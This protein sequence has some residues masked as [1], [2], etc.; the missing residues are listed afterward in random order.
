[1]AYR[2]TL[3]GSTDSVKHATPKALIILGTVA[4]TVAIHY[5]LILEPIFGHSGWVHAIHGRFCYI[6]IVIA[7]SWFGIRGGLITASVVS[8]S[9]LPYIF[10]GLGHV[11]NR[12][13][14]L[15][16]LVFYFAIAVLT[17]ALIDR[18]WTIRKKQEQTQLQLER[19]HKLSIIGQMAAS[20]AHE[21]KNPLAS[22]KGAV[23]II[24]DERT[25]AE[26]KREFRAIA[27]SE[28]KRTDG[29]IKE[30][31]AFARPRESR[32]EKLDLSQS[33]VASAR[34]IEV[35]TSAKQVRIITDIPNQIYI[36]GDSEKIHQAVINLLLNALEASPHNSQIS[37]SLSAR[38]NSAEVVIADRG[39]GI[40]AA[41]LERVFEPFYTTKA[42]GT[43]LGL[44][45]V[46]AIVENHDGSIEISS[47]PGVGTTVTVSI[48]RLKE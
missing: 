42:S 48:P 19:A 24:G 36:N 40:A 31:L 39:A 41:D 23:E 34:Q 35:Q 15:V 46:K 2:R 26:Q 28:I 43:G 6:P 13:V 37:L 12:S 44:A 3:P 10:L 17:G 29:T 45:V 16:E 47:Q 32:M 1:M 25:P 4:L 14:E 38:H 9:V 20:V 21:I 30:F 8:L 7:A 11:S 27:L 33:L 22:I 5:G 18:E